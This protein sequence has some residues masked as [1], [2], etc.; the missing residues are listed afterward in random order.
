MSKYKISIILP[1]YNVEKYIEKSVESLINQSIGFENLQVILIDDNSSDHSAEIVKRY[2]TKYENVYGIYLTVNSH[3]AG[4]PRNE[5]LNIVAGEYVMFLDPD[6]MYEPDACENLYREMREGNYDCV[7]GYYKEIDEDDKVV[8]ENVYA[9]MEV[10]GGVYD[11]ENDLEDVLKFRSGFWAKIYKSDLIEKLKLRFPENVPGQ[12][13]VFFIKYLLNCKNLRYVE[14]PIVDYR[15]RNKK[16]K[17]IS[18][19]YN[20][21][22]FSGISQSYKMCLE[23]FEEKSVADKYA[24]LF[25]GALDFYIRSMIDSDLK[26]KVIATILAEWQWAYEYETLHEQTEKNFWYT[27][28]SKLLLNKEYDKAA[29]VICEMR[30]L[31]NWNNEL[32]E[33]AEWHAKNNESLQKQV[34]ELKEWSNELKEAVEWHKNNGESLQRQINELKNWV[35]QIEEARDYY[36]CQMENSQKEYEKA[37]DLNKKLQERINELGEGPEQQNEVNQEQIDMYERMEMEA[38][39][40][41]YKYNRLMSDKTIEKIAK[42]K[43]LDI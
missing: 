35:T 25:K 9:A 31:R 13:L 7:A 3:A 12:D 37:I 16:N 43:N 28:V 38:K 18:F 5:G 34:Q 21:W 6:D 19:S 40:W 32:K 1:V 22:F 27:P 33:A 17:S 36:K 14:K 29:D 39:K 24:I 15:V 11:I 41:K 4:K 10:A 30:N 42:K 23:T 26:E 20:E 2:E 8:N